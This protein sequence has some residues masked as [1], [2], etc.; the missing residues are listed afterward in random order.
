MCLRR[1]AIVVGV[2]G[3]GGERAKDGAHRGMKKMEE[4]SVTIKTYV[5]I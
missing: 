2:T 3:V 5:A 1:A 4:I